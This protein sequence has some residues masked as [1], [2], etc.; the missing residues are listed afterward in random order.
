MRRMGEAITTANIGASSRRL[1]KS[2][3]IAEKVV[4]S[5]LQLGTSA[6]AED[7]RRRGR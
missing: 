3:Q 4:A 5:P 6:A 7:L 1:P 2:K